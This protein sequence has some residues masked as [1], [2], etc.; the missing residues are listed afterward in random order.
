MRRK[1]KMQYKTTDFVMTRAE[2]NRRRK[3]RWHQ[4]LVRRIGLRCK[5]VVLNLSSIASDVNDAH[6]HGSYEEY[7]K[8]RNKECS[9]ESEI[10]AEL[11]SPNV[12]SS[13]TRG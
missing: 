8:R 10:L 13:G 3:H 5:L 12:Q 7:V 6:S 11:N 9:E 2:L 1:G 4:R